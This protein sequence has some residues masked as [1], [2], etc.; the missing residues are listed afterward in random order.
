M[1]K[2]GE[3]LD[4]LHRD[5]YKLIQ[6][7]KMFCFG[8]DAVLLSDF[9]RAKPDET[10]LDMCCGNGIV[11]ILMEAKTQCSQFVGIEIQEYNVDMAMRSVRY[12]NLQDKIFIEHGDLRELD[13]LYNLHLFDV[14]TCNPPYIQNDSGAANLSKEKAIA[15]HEI[16][17][18]L[19]DIMHSASDMLKYGGRF[20]MVHRVN[21]IV[22][23]FE[24]SRKYSLEPKLLRFV[25]AMHD[26]AP[27]MM[28][29]EFIKNG[30]PHLEVMA[31]L[32]L[33]AARG[34]CSK[35]FHDI[36]YNTREENEE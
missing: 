4:D 27:S 16:M 7:P 36:L 26:Q 15:R 35:E 13:K 29:I 1:L 33:Y 18:T 12:N 5:G 24:L 32:I 6:N 2:D 3:R 11:P 34:V 23:I 17:C 9:A 31:P 25:H 30:K 22:D 19:D 20:Y 8:L 21:R 28:L 10:V 14:V